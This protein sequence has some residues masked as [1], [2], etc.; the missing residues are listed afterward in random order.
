MIINGNRRFPPVTV[1]TA[2]QI[3]V[4]GI[5]CEEEFFTIPKYVFF[6]SEMTQ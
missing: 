6:T 3:T 5:L 1:E 2:A 4:D